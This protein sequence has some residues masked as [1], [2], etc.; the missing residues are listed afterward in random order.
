MK[1]QG[2][3]LV[4]ALLVWMAW[5]MPAAAGPAQ[6]TPEETAVRALVERWADAWSK[7]DIAAYLES[8]AP[9]FRPEG[10]KGGHA[11]WVA[12]R[13][14]RILGR[15]WIRVAIRDLRLARLGREWRV[16]FFQR[17]R[18]D[19]YQ[20]EVFKELRIGRVNGTWRII[21]ERSTPVS[22]AL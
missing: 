14:A 13:R 11:A 20:D 4:A 2:R 17:Y 22:G 5:A 12:Q 7:R 6:P 21:R 15:R 3:S 8:Y 18:S 19:R 9:D 1:R 16:T 10:M